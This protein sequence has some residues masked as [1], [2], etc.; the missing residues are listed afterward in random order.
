MDLD[1]KKLTSQ[2]SSKKC[3][4]SWNKKRET[5]NVVERLH[6][7]LKDRIKPLRGLKSEETVRSTRFLSNEAKM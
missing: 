7:T 3:E 5:N 6:G 2:N 1:I 4:K